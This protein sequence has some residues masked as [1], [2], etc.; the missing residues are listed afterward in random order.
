MSKKIIL[1]GGGTAGHVIPNIAI[2]PK[3]IER[4]YEIIYIGS[5]NGIEK[6]LI[7]NENIKYYGISTGKLR[8]YFDVN[9]FKDPF[10]V[11]KGIFEASK[12]LKKEKPDIVFSKGGFVSIPVILGAR[13]NKIPVISHESD[14]TPGL[15][16]KIS[17]PFTKKIC[18]TFPETRKFIHDKKVEFTGTPIRRD[19]FLGS[20]TRGKEICKFNNDKPN[21]MI[22]GG[23]Q[24]SVFINNIIRKN[25]NYLL[26][27]FNV[28]HICGKNNLDK[29]LFNK[30]GYVQY[31][32]VNEEQPHLFKI[33]DIIISRAGSNSIYELLALKKP[34][35]LIPLSKRASRGDQVLN[36]KSFKDRGFSE[37]IEEEEL[38]SFDVLKSKL[39]YLYENRES[40]INNMISEYENP[41]DKIVNIIDKYSN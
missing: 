40:Y 39:E 4:G 17:I 32:Y 12:I 13:K 5:K 38:T 33:S 1:T 22:M 31:E 29:S 3:L 7:E 23:S 27:N 11:I 24:G 36:A 15:A 6:K 10:K 18:I 16:N 28:I 35:I 8:R 19:L 20:E 14:I 25:L 9:N 2:I 26:S 37:M 41:I 30:P 34:N 21:I